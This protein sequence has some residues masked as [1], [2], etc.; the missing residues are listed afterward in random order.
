MFI[1][2]AKGFIQKRAEA[3]LRNPIYCMLMPCPPVETKARRHHADWPDPAI[4]GE[5]LELKLETM[6]YQPRL[7]LES[8]VASFYPRV[9]EDAWNQ[10]PAQLEAKAKLIILFNEN[11]DGDKPITKALLSLFMEFFD[12]YFFRGTLGLDKSQKGRKRVWLRFWAPT[13]RYAPFYARELFLPDTE[14]GFIRELYMRHYGPIFEIHMAGPQFF[15]NAPRLLKYIEILLHQMVN[16]Y[17]SLYTCRCP[18]CRNDQ[19][20]LVG[21]R[22]NHRSF[23]MLM[24]TIDQTLRSWARCSLSAHNS[25]ESENFPVPR[26]SYEDMTCLCR[27][28]KNHIE[29]PKV[30]SPQSFIPPFWQ[31]SESYDTLAGIYT[32]ETPASPHSTSNSFAVQGNC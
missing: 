20:K 15:D 22:G 21:V 27:G 7:L 19:Y 24:D 3:V 25:A 12:A 31:G 6:A 29:S 16:V 4:V 5:T 9:S 14:N 10:T 2:D 26:M 8:T 13:D 18:P 30:S 1:T 28:K 23:L 11:K 32:P 17:L